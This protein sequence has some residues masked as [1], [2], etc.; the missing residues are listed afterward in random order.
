MIAIYGSADAGLPFYHYTKIMDA[1]QRDAAYLS[2]R[3]NGSTHVDHRLNA[4]TSRSLG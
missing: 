1:G 2:N 4:N 3:S